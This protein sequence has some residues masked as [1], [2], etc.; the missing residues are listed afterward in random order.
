MDPAQIIS[1]E[2]PETAKRGEATEITVVTSGNTSKLQL[3]L[4]SGSTITYTDTTAN[5][6]ENADGTKTWTISR[7][8][9]RSGEYD[10]SLAA[11]G[12]AGWID[13]ATYATITVMK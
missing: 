9:T 5:V 8:Y 13:Y 2:A 3:K 1:V 10:I 4:P 7:I 6:E 11:K 12:P